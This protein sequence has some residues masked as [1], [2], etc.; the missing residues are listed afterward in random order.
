MDAWW[1]QMS[2]F[3]HVL[4]IVAIP[5]TLLLLVQLALSLLGGLE[6]GVHDGSGVDVHA[7]EL[8]GHFQLLTVRNVVAFFAMFGWCG[9]ALLHAGTPKL[10]I[11]G[12]GLLAGLLTMAVLALIFMGISQLASSGTM[13]LRTAVN[14]TGSVYVPVP[15]RRT[16]T[17]KV[18]VT[19]S[20]KV[21]EA[22][23][24]TDEDEKI[25]TGLSVRVKEVINGKLLIE[26]E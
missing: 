25:G 15:P 7:G 12:G 10:V 1:S 20:G 8:G 19:V 21:V 4:W 11:V 9:L 17:G 23:A 16:G 26:R 18:N 22:D 2:G 5:A 24:M 3:E 14:A 13:D 6:F